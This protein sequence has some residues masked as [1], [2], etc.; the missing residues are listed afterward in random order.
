MKKIALF[1]SVAAAL[2]LATAVQAG[3]AI[4]NDM[5]KC[6]AGKGPAVLVTVRGIKSSN[7]KIRV[8]NYPATKSAWLQKGMWIN[9][10][11]TRA[12]AGALSYCLPLPKAGNYAIAVRHDVNSNGNTD[13]RQDGGGMSN[14]PSINVFNLGK[15]A[16]G[17]VSFA[18]GAGVTRITINMKYM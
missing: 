1:T 10:I 7:G 15:P 13:L 3:T 12:S 11:E 18:A 5:A 8:Q 4:R 6:G 17:K 16:V 2:I 14:N 9:R